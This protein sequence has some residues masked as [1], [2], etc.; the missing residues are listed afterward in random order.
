MTEENLVHYIASYDK[1]TCQC[2]KKYKLPEGFDKIPAP[3]IKHERVGR[4]VLVPLQDV[5]I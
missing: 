5:Q 1:C 3:S 4:C 2:H